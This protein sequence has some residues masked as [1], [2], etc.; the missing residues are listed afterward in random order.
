MKRDIVKIIPIIWI[1]LMQV[2]L[3]GYPKNFLIKNNFNEFFLGEF[4]LQF[5][6]LS[7]SEFNDLIS[8]MNNKLSNN[9]LF[10]II[11]PDLTIDRNEFNIS[12]IHALYIA[13]ADNIKDGNNYNLM[14]FCDNITGSLYLFDSYHL[15]N[16]DL[17]LCGSTLTNLTSINKYD[18]FGEYSYITSDNLG[19]F[20]FVNSRLG[21]IDRYE[22]DPENQVFNKVGTVN[23]FSSPRGICFSDL[24]TELKNDDRLYIANYSGGNIYI[25]PAY[26]EGTFH[27]DDFIERRYFYGESSKIYDR[28]IAIVCQNNR[29][30]G[31]AG[32]P[33]IFYLISE[34]NL[35]QKLKDDGRQIS[36]LSEY[37]YNKVGANFVSCAIDVD[38]DIYLLDKYRSKIVKIKEKNGEYLMLFEDGVHGT[39]STVE[40]I[41]FYYP[42]S[43]LG[44]GNDIIISEEYTAESGAQR[45][46]NVPRIYDGSIK[47]G[48]RCGT[49]AVELSFL[50]TKK[51]TIK[52]NIYDANK[53]DADNKPIVIY[54]S[55]N[56]GFTNIEESGYAN[57]ILPGLSYSYL[58]SYPNPEGLEY[59]RVEV[60]IYEYGQ[61]AQ[62]TD[63]SSRLLSITTPRVVQL[64]SYVS[65]KENIEETDRVFNPNSATES[66]LKYRFELTN[67]PGTLGIWLV[68]KSL[69]TDGYKYSGVLAETPD[70][71]ILDISSTYTENQRIYTGEWH[72]DNSIIG[73]I[74]G[75]K[76]YMFI[77][78]SMDMCGTQ[79]AKSVNITY[80][81]YTSNSSF[82]IVDQTPPVVSASKEANK[83]G[84]T[85]NGSGDKQ[86]KCVYTLTNEA[87]SVVIQGYVFKKADYI[88]G[89]YAYSA[90]SLS[91]YVFAFTPGS[92][93]LD[94][95][96]PTYNVER[97][98]DGKRSDGTPALDDEYIFVALSTDAAGNMLV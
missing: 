6:E 43:I 21:I 86:L 59:F 66:Y 58:E 16:Y 39:N 9:G 10:G 95:N 88:L 30:P 27:V 22:Y 1:L 34:G 29:Q 94:E 60:L 70:K 20:W 7:G 72:P 65:C 82:I 35:L 12:S 92:S 80:A 62:N 63:V 46:K 74:E 83:I 18:N 77:S 25:I 75:R 44:Y 5:E 91:N 85:F 84:L 28:P 32:S 11:C 50:I 89:N 19:T 73:L 36:I 26:Y 61:T 64:S 8:S 49:D 15:K 57:V 24:G 4:G 54:S 69:L 42:H 76:Y 3:Y 98:W 17:G 55:D 48:N 56:H 67:N 14:L 71:K 52:V 90:G 53:L 2:D 79:E 47:L 96:T 31:S 51:A 37:R 87:S 81:P 40:H 33:N 41:E 78:P 97:T 93:F 45:F 38:K 68:E 13:P 23:G